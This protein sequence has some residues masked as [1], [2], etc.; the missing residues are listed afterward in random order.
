M[1]ISGGKDTPVDLLFQPD[2]EFIRKRCPLMSDENKLRIEQIG[3]IDLGHSENLQ[4]LVQN[5]L[6]RWM[7]REAG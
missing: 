1:L 2:E 3:Q 4:K 7:R 5:R 6:S